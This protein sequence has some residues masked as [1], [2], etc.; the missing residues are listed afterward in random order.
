MRVRPE[1]P[2]EGVRV[3]C[4][5]RISRPA[6]RSANASRISSFVFMTKGPP[7]ATGSSMIGLAKMRSREAVAA[8][9]GSV[10]WRRTKERPMRRFRPSPAASPRRARP[11]LREHRRRRAGRR[12]WAHRTLRRARSPDRSGSSAMS[13]HARRQYRRAR[14]HRR[15]PRRPV[16]VGRR[17]RSQD[18]LVTRRNALQPGRKIE[19]KLEALHAS[20]AR[21]LAVHDAPARGHE[22]HI[23]RAE[24]AGP[25]SVIGMD[26]LAGE[27]KVRSRCPG[28]DGSENRPAARTSPRPST[29]TG[30]ARRHPRAG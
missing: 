24:A 15:A 14:P 7:I 29:G 11:R 21:H 3:A 25:A 1:G 28:G 4:L 17:V 6:R 20:G 22:L 10:S 12:E 9:A 18:V 13:T 27:D 8:R 19:P 5:Y 26:E 23:A 2:D 30:C 16:R